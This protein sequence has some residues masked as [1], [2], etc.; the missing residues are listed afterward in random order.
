MNNKG[1]LNGVAELVRTSLHEAFVVKQLPND[2]E[3]ERFSIAGGGEGWVAYIQGR[4]RWRGLEFMFEPQGFGS[5]LVRQAETALVSGNLRETF[6]RV[7]RHR[8]RPRFDIQFDSVSHKTGIAAM[9]RNATTLRLSAV[10]SPYESRRADNSIDED[11]L[12]ERTAVFLQLVLAACPVLELR[13]SAQPQDGSLASAG[14]DKAEPIV[15]GGRYDVRCSRIERSGVARAMC[16]AIHGTSC[17]V[18]SIDFSKQYGSIGDGYIHVH[19]LVPLSQQPAVHT[20]DPVKDLAP[21][22]PNCHAM[23]HRRIP[24]L[25]PEQLRA[26]LSR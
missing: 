23:L 10:F 5:F 21:V 13:E 6:E 7:E 14:A 12:V 20:V 24:P 15:E 18:C 11:G 2:L 4:V 26:H 19:H 8:T 25:T 9:P 16:L 22:C 1:Y 3:G 17:M